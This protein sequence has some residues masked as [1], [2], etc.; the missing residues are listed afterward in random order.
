[1]E[2]RRCNIRGKGGKTGGVP[3]SRLEEARSNGGKN[4]EGNRDSTRARRD[5]VIQARSN[6]TRKQR[7]VDGE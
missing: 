4:K 6:M 1:M 5:A 2:T 7:K 3:Y